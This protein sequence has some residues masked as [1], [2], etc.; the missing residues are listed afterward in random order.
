MDHDQGCGRHLHHISGH[1]HNG[2]SRGRNACDPHRH[3]AGIIPQHGVNLCRSTHVTARAID[4]QGN[5]T[6]FRIQFI[7]EHLRRNLIAPEGFRIN[8]SFQAEHPAA[9]VIVNPVPK[10]HHFRFPP[11]L[12]ALRWAWR[13]AAFLLSCCSSCSSPDSS[14]GVSFSGSSGSSVSVFSCSATAFAP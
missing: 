6:L 8:R 10:L 2:S 3:V 5:V 1:G 12:C 4:P 7:T 9:R 14:S 13:W 11:L